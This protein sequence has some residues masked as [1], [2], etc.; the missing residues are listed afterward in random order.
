VPFLLL[1]LALILGPIYTARA[2]GASSEVLGAIK[3]TVAAVALFV[4][5]GLYKRGT[6]TKSP[7]STDSDK[8]P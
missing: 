7:S 6:G 5:Y 3:L 2:L 8:R 1:L 4:C